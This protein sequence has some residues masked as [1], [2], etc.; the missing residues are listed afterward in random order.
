MNSGLFKRIVFLVVSL[1]AAVAVAVAA[2]HGLRLASVGAAYKAKIVCSDLFVSHRSY[3]AILDTDLAGERL[4][5]LRH[6]D[7]K[8]DYDRK[9]VTAGL[10]GFAKR[11]AAY[12]PGFGCTLVYD[13][14]PV[15]AVTG[16]SAAPAAPPSIPVQ[17]DARFD[18]ALDW[19]F[20]EPDPAHLRLTRA[21][22]VLHNGRIVAERYAPGIGRDSPLIG[23]SMSKSVMNALAG[24]AVAEG[25]LS[26][27]GPL[28]VPEWSVPGDHRRKITLDDLLYMSSGLHFDEDYANPLSDAT[29]ML[30]SVPDMADFAAQKPL[31]AEPGTR[32]QYSSGTTNLISRTLRFAVGESNYAD[33]PR[34]ALFAP[35]GMTGAVFERDA[36][37][38]FIG[39]SFLYATARDWALFGQLY[40]QDGVWAGRRI[41]PEGWVKYSTTPAPRAPDKEYGA[42]FWLKI[43]KVFLGPGNGKA[44]PAD[45]FHAVGYEGQFVTVI[46]SRK[47]V[48]VRLGC[49]HYPPAWQHDEFV[50]QV[51]AAADS[52]F[53]AKR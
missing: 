14:A 27:K 22:V 10:F 6:M 24:I 16:T 28:S 35:V 12:H 33:F 46:P 36:S 17:Y 51:L 40:L 1:A 21:V 13:G 49:T 3:Q 39:S 42:H 43:P 18:K 8:V 2:L 5:A 38:T 7:V 23:W 34:R 19:A 20:A 50:A 30:F 47:M 48:I 45:T 41:L 32:W 4:A 26:L 9:E 37:G 53:K 29:C 52:V 25:K 15:H 31:D 11:K 44:F